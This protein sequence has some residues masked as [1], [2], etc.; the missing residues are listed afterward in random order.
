MNNVFVDVIFLMFTLWV[1]CK[2]FAY[3]MYEIK[4]ENNLF[5]GIVTMVFS[6]ASVVFSNVMVWIN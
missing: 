3:S 1:L 4:S 2:I 5:G 6:V